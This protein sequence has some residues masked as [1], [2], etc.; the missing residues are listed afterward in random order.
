MILANN[1]LF[2]TLARE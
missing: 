1:I 2:L